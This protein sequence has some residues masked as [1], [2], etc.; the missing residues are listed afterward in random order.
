[1][2]ILFGNVLVAVLAGGLAM[3]RDM[4]FFGIYQPGGITFMNA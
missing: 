4:K 2:E 1:M 3:D